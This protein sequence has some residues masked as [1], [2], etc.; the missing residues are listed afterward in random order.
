MVLDDLGIYL[1]TQGLG[2]LGTNIFKGRI[3]Q[4]AP[5]TGVPDE[6]IALFPVPG[7]PP[8]HTHDIVGPAVEQ[9]MVQVRIRGGTT[10][11]SDA[12]AWT[13]AQQAFVALDSVRNQVINGV[14]YR[15]IMAMSSP[16]GRLGADQWN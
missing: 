13:K 10:A 1:Q 3:P 4:D 8:E 7:L 12:S 15:Q 14:F 9:P 2:T 6:L 5:G 11:G 16:D